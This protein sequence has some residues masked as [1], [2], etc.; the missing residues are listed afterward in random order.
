LKTEG[1]AGNPRSSLGSSEAM[2]SSPVEDL[3]LETT[4]TGPVRLR[5]QPGLTVE[6]LFR[7][8][9][10]AVA[11][12]VR[13]LLGPNASSADVE[14]VTQQTFIAA[15]R[16]L[17]RFRG[18]SSPTTWL[19]GIASN[20]VLMHLRSWR[21][22]R[23]TLE[24]FFEQLRT[25]DGAAPDLERR[26]EHREEL[27]RVWKCLEK[28]KP[29]KRVVFVLFEIEGLSAAEIAT[30]LQIPQATVFTRLHH[31]RRELVEALRKERER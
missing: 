12:I 2:V 25:E 16:A 5:A 21:R 27:E 11:R 24:A 17:E 23:R 19:Y 7:R 8:H 15:E 13:R 30:A 20:A 22:R 28:I 29:K 31:A 3:P 10:Q 14:D 26:Y 6:D 4:I 1:K 9:H 18:D